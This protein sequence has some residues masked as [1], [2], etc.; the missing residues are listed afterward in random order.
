MYLPKNTKKQTAFMDT[1]LEGSWPAEERSSY[2]EGFSSAELDTCPSLIFSYRLNPL[3][4]K[5]SPCATD[6]TASKNLE[7]LYK[8]HH[9]T[10]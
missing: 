5:P 10:P 8:V 7:N 1:M 2:Q 6:L 4:F 9:A 3:S